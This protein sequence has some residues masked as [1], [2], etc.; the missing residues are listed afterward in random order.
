MRARA[1]GGLLKSSQIDWTWWF[2]TV[3]WNSAF[4][5][6]FLLTVLCDVL[7][8]MLF[9]PPHSNSTPPSSSPRPC[10]SSPLLP[11]P[12]LKSCGECL[13][14]RESGNHVMTG[15]LESSSSKTGVS[16]YLVCLLFVAH[17]FTDIHRA[18]FCFCR[19]PLLSSL[20]IYFISLHSILC[21]RAEDR[22]S[23]P[24]RL[25]L[26][27]LHH[28]LPLRG[29]GGHP[30][31][32]AYCWRYSHHWTNGETLMKLTS[33]LCPAAHSLNIFLSFFFFFPRLHWVNVT[34]SGSVA[35][36][37]GPSFETSTCHACTKSW[38]AFCLVA[39][40]ASRSP[41]W[42]SWAWDACDPISCPSVISLT[43]PSTA[44]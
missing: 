40:W 31:Q 28:H 6:V 18:I 5:A 9:L 38:E 13:N 12:L 23:V 29:A 33:C 8:H 10:L 17:T 24:A 44:A 2:S 21:L 11:D 27:R 37:L 16:L 36:T 15:A 7:P 4:H 22:D 32:S 41:T 26:W 14:L 25:L 39:A 42:Q 34:G 20:S 19:P 3:K 35:C 1:Y 43:R 30:R